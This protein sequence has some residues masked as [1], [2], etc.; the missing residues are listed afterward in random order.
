MRYNYYVLI[1][2]SIIIFV[3]WFKDAKIKEDAQKLK[4]FFIILF[5]IMFSLSFL[6]VPKERQKTNKKAP[7]IIDYVFYLED[8]YTENVRIPIRNP[9]NEHIE[10]S[11][12]NIKNLE[13]PPFIFK[14]IEKKKSYNKIR[15]DL[16]ICNIGVFGGFLS[17][18]YF[19]LS[20]K[21][22]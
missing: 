6:I 19:I 22:K 4:K 1:F 16:I 13:D 2:I 17:L 10:L 7:V 12:E 20:K 3:L 8:N 5:L 15:F 21:I 9:K 14:N 11:I 18:L